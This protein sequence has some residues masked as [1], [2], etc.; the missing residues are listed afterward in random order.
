M[1]RVLRGRPRRVRLYLAGS[2]AALPSVV[3]VWSRWR[4]EGPVVLLGFPLLAGFLGVAAWTLLRPPGRA[5]TLERVAFSA[6]TGLWLLQVAAQLLL[7]GPAAGWSQVTPWSFLF[8][9]LMAVFGY[10]VFGTREALHYV[11]PIPVL[12]TV[13][14]IVGLVPHAAVTGDWFRVGELLRYEM[15]LLLTIVFVHALALHKDDAAAAQLEAQR[16]RVIAHHDPLTGLPNRRR[17]EEVLARQVATADAQGRPLSVITFDLD[18]FK[19]V[20]DRHGH[21]VGDLVL[22]QAGEAVTRAAR[23]RDTVGRWGGEEFLV[24]VPGADEE[25]AE[26]VAERL[27]AAV[28][29]ETYAHGV[30]V[31]ASFGVAQHRPGAAVSEILAAADAGLYRAK[32]AGRDAVRG[33]G[34]VHV[35]P[36]PESRSDVERRAVVDGSPVVEGGPVVEGSHEAPQHA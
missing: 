36:R 33:V 7:G 18:H 35:P 3:S 16:L 31:T 29:E 32:D 8:L 2:L 14:G 27:R 12:S 30:P 34:G 21:A 10:V 26:G 4:D 6:V 20:N 17:L 19:D 11:S 5:R 23:S 25:Q 28:A 13:V 9:S 24:V 15:F 22:R 1:L